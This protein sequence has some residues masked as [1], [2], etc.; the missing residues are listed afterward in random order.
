[1]KKVLTQKE[2]DDRISMRIAVTFYCIWLAI[3][4]YSFYHID[5][6][7]GLVYDQRQFDWEYV[8]FSIFCT[9]DME[10][11]E[12][13]PEVCVVCVFVFRLVGEPVI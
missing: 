13:F 8:R 2:Y 4:L 12:R 9:F 7:E 6:K 5:R 11:G 1:M 3:L 10:Y